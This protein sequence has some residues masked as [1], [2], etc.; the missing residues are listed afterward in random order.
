MK[1]IRQQFFAS[2][3]HLQASCF[4]LVLVATLAPL[5]L[6]AQQTKIVW[7]PQEQPIVDQL[8][9]LRKL[10]DDDRVGATQK[11]ALQ[12]RQLPAVPNKVILASWLTGLSTEGDFGHDTLQ[13][14]ATTLAD[15]L[16]QQPQPD[17]KGQ[18]AEPYMQ[19]ASLVH[20]EHVQAALESPEYQAAMAKLRADDLLRQ[21]INFT[22]ADLN[23]KSWTLQDLH[24]KVVLVNFWAT[25]CP[26]CR[27]EMPDLESLYRQFGPQGLVVLAISDEDAAKVKSFLEGRGITYPI[28][29]DPGRKVTES[30][31][32]DGIPKSFVY[33]R[34]GKLVAQSID[35][36][37][38]QQFLAM[39][40]QAGLH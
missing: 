24:G 6:R 33:D 2:V 16:R 40:A 15:T 18:P 39:L 19:L 13:E 4:A 10:P 27:K 23:G 25:W 31:Q 21:K 9:G 17:V 5:P 11:L 34:E 1:A 3:V 7:T 38:K 8:K 22:L 12:I 36:R 37:T 32:V 20:Y 30:F 26:P 29:L 14:V 35:M 28:L